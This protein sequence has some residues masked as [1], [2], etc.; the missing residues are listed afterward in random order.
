MNTAQTKGPGERRGQT[1]ARGKHQARRGAA[2]NGGRAISWAPE[3]IAP[4]GWMLQ[5][6]VNSR[7]AA[8]LPAER[9]PSLGAG[10]IDG[11]ARRLPSR[12]RSL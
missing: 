8:R 9:R 7:A 3:V 11:S 2:L 5:E 1:H 12:A 10:N 6:R 4:S